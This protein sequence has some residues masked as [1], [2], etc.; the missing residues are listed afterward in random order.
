MILHLQMT[1]GEENHSTTKLINFIV[2]RFFSG[3]NAI[4][5]RTSLHKFGIVSSFYQC[6][7]FRTIKGVYC[8]QGSQQISRSCYMAALKATDN[9]PLARKSRVKK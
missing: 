5:E 2:V 6:L 7:K 9:A 1:L 8:I 4:L 3:Y